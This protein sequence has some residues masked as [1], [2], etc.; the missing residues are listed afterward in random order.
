MR[1]L[2]LLQLGLLLLSFTVQAQ[3][4]V[5]GSRDPQQL[6]RF[7][8][9]WIVNFNEQQIPEYELATGPMR[10]IGG[11]IAPEKSQRISGNLLRITY[12]VP[13]T[14]T[15]AQ[16]FNYY[17][18]LLESLQATILFQCSSRQCGSSNQWA[19]NYFDIA[20]LYGIDR[21]QFFISANLGQQQL[22]FYTV[23]RGNR[24]SYVQLDL[25]QSPQQSGD[26]LVSD[27]QQRGVSWLNHADDIEPLL[28]YMRNNAQQ[29]VLIG[30]YD[31]RVGEFDDLVRQSQQAAD[32]FSALLIAKGIAAER[33]A[34]V[35]VGPALPLERASLVGLWVQV[36]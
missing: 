3:S 12:R 29:K 5:T 18:E 10:K 1:I 6:P 25:I 13:D 22:A 35:G 17:H 19:N 23:Q 11:V 4:D 26:S 16:V 32:A 8:L 20:E 36:R 9:S 30:G 33:I 28:D 24:R 15:P 14:H 34:S 27:L 2:T 21:S 7:P 31:K